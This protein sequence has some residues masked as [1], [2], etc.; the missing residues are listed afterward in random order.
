[1]G[2]HAL[3]SRR[4][5]STPAKVVA[6]A[7]T[8]AVAA[9]AVSAGVYASWNT[10][11]ALTTGTYS[12]ATVSSSFVSTGTPVFSSAVSNL[13]PGDSV[14]RYGDLQNTSSV[15]LAMSIATSGSGALA[16]GLALSVHSCATAYVDGVC[17]EDGDG[18]LVTSGSSVTQ[19]NLSLGTIAASGHVYLKVKSTLPANAD[20]ATYAGTSG[21]V[22]VTATGATLAGS[23][24]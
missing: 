5:M 3:R 4:R 13:V 20:Q 18:T 9:A 12:A 19:S 22:T 6:T 15:S 10:S 11:G 14:T 21:T 1:M 7:G 17:G 23:A 8:V 16:P 2:K 24:R